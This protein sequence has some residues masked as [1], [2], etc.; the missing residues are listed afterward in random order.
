MFIRGSSLG[1]EY[2][3]KDLNFYRGVIVKNDDPLKLNRV[4]VYIPELSNQP[5]EEWFA[6]ND[7]L[8]VKAPG[9]NGENDSWMDTKIFEEIAAII[10]WADPCY[11]VMGESSN[12]RYYKDDELK[13]ISDC[14]FVVG[15]DAIDDKPPTLEEGSF[16]P[17]FLYEISET[18]LGDAF[19][20]PL[21]NFAVNNNPYAF[22]YSPIKKSNEAKGIFGI[23][24]VGSKVW[25]FHYQGDLNFPVYFGT[26]HDYRE[27]ATINNVTGDNNVS[28]SYPSD[29]E[30]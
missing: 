17:A 11:P 3:R 23:P 22:Q 15:F 10:P 30:N 8:E 27:L 13:T 1:S 24:N 28:Q 25:V 26:S 9:K 6:D 12:Y 16:A 19:S 5:Y 29:F 20:R 4:K 21:D 14:N 7:L 2:N 18:S